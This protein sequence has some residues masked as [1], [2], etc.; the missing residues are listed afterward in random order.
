MRNRDIQ[1][2]NKI[3]SIIHLPTFESSLQLIPCRISHSFEDYW[4]Y[5][6]GYLKALFLRFLI[7]KTPTGFSFA[8][9]SIVNLTR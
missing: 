8:M 5:F 1:T 7:K 3:F 2:L 6:D 4:T 9:G